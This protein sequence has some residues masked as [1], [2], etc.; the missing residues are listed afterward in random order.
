MLFP[1]WEMVV[2]Y[3]FFGRFSSIYTQSRKAIE[4]PINIMLFGKAGP[5]NPR[6]IKNKGQ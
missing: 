2:N 5:E 1:I 6:E 3:I 4:F